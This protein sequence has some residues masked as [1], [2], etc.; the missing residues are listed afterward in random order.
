MRQSTFTCKPERVLPVN[1]TVRRF[2]RWI[3][4]CQSTQFHWAAI[5]TVR[6]TVAMG[7]GVWSSAHNPLF[8]GHTVQQRGK[9]TGFRAELC[10]PPLSPQVSLVGALSPVAHTGLYQGYL[11]TSSPRYHHEALYWVDW[12]HTG[13]EC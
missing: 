5:S 6:K 10:A 2:V 12:W 7:G 13:L 11:P 1:N 3:Q 4:E 9:Y 8:C